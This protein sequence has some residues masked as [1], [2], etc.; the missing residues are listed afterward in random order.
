MVWYKSSGG[1]TDVVIS[2]RVCLLRNLENYPFSPRL[3]AKGAAEIISRVGGLLENNG[4]QAFSFAEIPQNLAY[5]YYEKKYVSRRFLALSTPHALYL[6]ETECCS[7]MLCEDNHVTV[8]SVLPG[9]AVE[10]AFAVA[11]KT[12]QLIDAHFDIAFDGELGYLSPNP[13]DLGHGAKISALVFL[14]AHAFYRRTDSLAK[15]LRDVGFT[16][17]PFFKNRPDLPLYLVTSLD[18]RAMSEEQI[19]RKFSGTL[20]QIVANEHT[21]R[22]SIALT[23]RDRIVDKAH[24]ALGILQNACFLSYDELLTLSVDIRTGMAVGEQMGTDNETLS[25]LWF[26]C[27]D[28]TLISSLPIQPKTHEEQDK[29]RASAVRYLL[30]EP[31]GTEA[32]VIH[33]QAFAE[34]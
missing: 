11:C 19:L 20:A 12:E 9:A 16:F 22:S 30:K 29:I 4:F 13:C 32:A 26:D 5:S 2:S 23:P 17:L 28:A 3:D 8:Q 7:V 25:S 6:N 24:R 15:Q 31:T 33:P 21:M 1:N 27:A 18:V 34:C 14:P 10:N